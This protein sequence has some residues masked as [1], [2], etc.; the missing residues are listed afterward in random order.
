M[1][2]AVDQIVRI[3][4]APLLVAQGLGIRRRVNQLAEPPGAREGHAGTGAPL[5]LLIIGDSSSAGVGAR[6]QAAALSGQLV[7]QFA[8]QFDV[9]WKLVG[10][11]SATTKVVMQRLAP[12]EAAPYDVVV[13]ALGV[14]DVTRGSSAHV[15]TTRQ[16]QLADLLVSKFGAKLIVASGLPPMG[17]YPKLPQ[18]LR[19]VLGQQA[20]RLDRALAELCDRHP[21]MSH[22]PLHIPFE[23]RFQASDGYHPSEEAYTLWAKMIADHI[24]AHLKI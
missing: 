6:T 19:W 10:E 12:I 9:R 18:P 24:R 13:S 5:R 4:L 17:A 22:L 21:V 2:P 8:E 14:N 20:K 11:T 1:L 15:W 23:P 16:G 3:P 7:G